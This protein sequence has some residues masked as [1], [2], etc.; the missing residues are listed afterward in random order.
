MKAATTKDTI[1]RELVINVVDG[2]VLDVTEMWHRRPRRIRVERV[3]IR[4]VDG[5]IRSLTALGGLVLK[6]GETSLGQG[7][8]Q[9]WVAAGTYGTP[10]DDA[11]EWARQFWNEAPNG[12]DYW[13]VLGSEEGTGDGPVR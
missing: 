12:V 13:A 6:N 3:T 11:P 10:I 5:K 1:V 4:I 7:D 8:K 2:P 9:V